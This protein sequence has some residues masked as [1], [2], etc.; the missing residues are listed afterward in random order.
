MNAVFW[1][2]RKSHLLACCQK[3]IEMQRNKLSNG[4]RHTSGTQTHLWNTKTP[5]TRYPEENSKEADFL[6]VNPIGY[7][8]HPQT[9]CSLPKLVRVIFTTQA[10]TRVESL[11]TFMKCT[12]FLPASSCLF[13][14]SKFP[15]YRPRLTWLFSNT[16]FIN[17]KS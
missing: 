12:F 6:L 9:H 4:I 14:D 5:T 10:Q 1:I 7:V 11:W 2:Q 17:I 8:C 15:F 3:V 13:S 16:V